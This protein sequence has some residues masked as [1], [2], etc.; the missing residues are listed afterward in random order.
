MKF[1]RKLISRAFLGAFS[2][3]SIALRWINHEPKHYK[4]KIEKLSGVW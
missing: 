2:S 1:A 3:K 4:K